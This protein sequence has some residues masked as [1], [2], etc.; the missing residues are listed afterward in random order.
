[1]PLQSEYSRFRRYVGDFNVNLI[2]DDFIEELLDDTTFELTGNFATP[3]T[4]FDALHGQYHDEV[5][6]KSA[7]NWW[8]NR[9]AELQEKHSQSIGSAT[10]EVGEKW[11]RAFQMIKDLNEQLD[12]IQQLQIDITIGN[13]SRYSKQTLRR[14]GGISEEDTNA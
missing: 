6:L 9:L 4:T 11:D 3:I 2:E 7:I 12:A 10:Q 13:F 8:W 5:I 1:M 14:I